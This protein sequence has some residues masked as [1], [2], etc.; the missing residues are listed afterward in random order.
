LQQYRQGTI[1]PQLGA[2]AFA[3]ALGSRNTR[4]VIVPFNLAQHV[5]QLRK[6]SEQAV[7]EKTS[8]ASESATSIQA[9]QQRPEITTTYIPPST[10]VERQLVEIWSALLGVDR[11]GIDDNFFE[12]GG[13][14]L[15]ATRVL[16]RI[17]DQLQVQLTLRNIFDASTVRVLAAEISR[18]L[19]PQDAGKVSE[20]REEIVF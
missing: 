11:I 9:E 3:R 20:E 18:G 1:S 4:V 12:L 8:I 19:V 7:S 10:N 6:P 14:S 15:L 17:R 2:E 13:H 16:A 5:E